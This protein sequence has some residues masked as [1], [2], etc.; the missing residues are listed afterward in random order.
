MNVI[1]KER[2]NNKLIYGSVPKIAKIINVNPETIRRKVKSKED[3]YL[4][5]DYEIYLDIEKI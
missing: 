1:L 2:N 3:I 4:K 5:G